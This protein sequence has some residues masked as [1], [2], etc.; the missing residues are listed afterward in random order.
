[1]PLNISHSLLVEDN[2]IIAMDCEDMLRDLGAETVGV[3]AT[4][5]EALSYISNNAVDFAL[6][7]LNI[8]SETSLPVASLLGKKQTPVLFATGEEGEQ[9]IDSL[10]LK[11]VILQKPYTANGLQEALGTLEKVVQ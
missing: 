9:D 2:A 5:E 8:G 6:L 11:T 7:D 4:V 1:M 10:E 3:C